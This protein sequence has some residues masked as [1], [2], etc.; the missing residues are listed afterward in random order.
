MRRARGC[1]GSGMADNGKFPTGCITRRMRP[2][3]SGVGSGA[4]A[5]ALTV[6][7]GAC[8]PTTEAVFPPRP[9]TYIS[10][11]EAVAWPPR[12]FDHRIEYGPAPQQYGE[13]RLP[14]GAGPH[15][16]AAVFH[17]GCWLSIADNDYMDGV[18]EA[19]TDAGW[20]TWNVEFRTL[21]QPGGE[22]P[23][24]FQDVAA[25]TDHL[26]VLAPRY[27]LDVARVVTVGHSSGGHLALWAASRHRI[28][29]G[30]TLW[31][32]DPLVPVGAIGLAAIADLE[33]YA[34]MDVPA[35]GETPVRLLGGTA[36]ATSPDRNAQASPA[37]LAPTGVPQI[38]F[39]GV[40]DYA[41]PPEHGDAYAQRM[42]PLG[43]DVTHQALPAASHFEVVA[44]GTPS[45]A[46]VWREIAVFLERV[47][48]RGDGF[49]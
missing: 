33:H 21:D 9:G 26:K 31:T 4:A 47:G 35:C 44:I 3:F 38:L 18:A 36:S 22:W 11:G 6:F 25:A 28:E 32:P 49:Q 23:G 14:A 42:Q 10:A 48:G 24:I 13:L 37:E 45:W 30:A 29:E 15:P 41:V 40:D 34:R 20:A 5:V 43:D 17:G 46:T 27:G 1:A 12:P 39:T 16:V 8:Q 19:L 7:V 2:P